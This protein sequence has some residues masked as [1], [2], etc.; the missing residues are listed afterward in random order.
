MNSYA[1]PNFLFVFFTLFILV[2]SVS[3]A[4]LSLSSYVFA[5]SDNASDSGKEHGNNG[6]GHDDGDDGGSDDGD[7]GGSDDGDDGGSDDGDDGG[8]DDGNDGGSDDGNDGGSQSN[9]NSETENDESN[10]NNEQK[11]VSQVADQ[12]VDDKYGHKV[13]YI[14]IKSTNN[15]TSF[16]PDKVTLTTGSTIV[17]LN[18]DNSEHR[19]TMGAESNSKYALL[20]S[21]ILPNGMVDHEFQSPGTYLYS[22]LNN[23]KSN[24]VITILDN[25]EKNGATSV[26]IED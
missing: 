25:S 24:G 13:F 8:S 21:L 18:Q 10:N 19:I 15:E 4:P 9:I 17:W 11:N 7:D 22:D 14:L 3:S 16:V 20:N 2:L 6:K 1:K 5:A 12:T 23:P 26:A